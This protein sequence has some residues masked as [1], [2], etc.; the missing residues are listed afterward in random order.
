MAAQAPAS[1]LG[2]LE[3]PQVPLGSRKGDVLSL[4]FLAASRTSILQIWRLYLLFLLSRR[5]RHTSQPCRWE[6]ALL[7]DAFPNARHNFSCCQHFTLDHLNPVVVLK[8]SDRK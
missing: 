8:L 3:S 5:R 7:E 1:I 6:A 2:I 4:Q